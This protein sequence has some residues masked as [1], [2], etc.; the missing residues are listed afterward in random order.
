[1]KDM[2]I[3]QYILSEMRE[4]KEL[5]T[6]KKEQESHRPENNIFESREQEIAFEG[7]VF[8]NADFST[9]A[10]NII[11]WEHKCGTIADVVRHADAIFCSNR[12]GRLTTR[13]ILTVLKN[14]G[15]NLLHPEFYDTVKHYYIAREE[16]NRLYKDS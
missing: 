4:I 15:L 2:D 5:L 12:C 8:S 7:T 9:R 3:L 14:K 1:M 13:E 11:K 6:L 10:Y 16:I